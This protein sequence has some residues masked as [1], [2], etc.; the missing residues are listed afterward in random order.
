MTRDNYAALQLKIEKEISRL[1][2]QAQALRARQ[3]APIITSIIR[4]M[5]EYEITPE[6][7]A[8]AFNK[9]RAARNVRTGAGSDVK[10]KAPQKVAPKYLDPATGNT[11]TGR[12]KT[13]RWIVQAEA[14]GRERT[15]FLINP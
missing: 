7:I 6:E 3:R 4:S 8:T 2:K 12:G 1:Q 14:D 11:W 5:R 10:T 15:E 9:N 13:P